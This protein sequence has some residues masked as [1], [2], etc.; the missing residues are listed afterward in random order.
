MK[1]KE[2]IL[3]EIA[4]A[5]SGDKGNHANIGIIARHKEGFIFLKGYLTIER[6]EQFFSP[7]GIHKIVRYELPNL[8]AFNFVL[9][10][11]LGGGGSLSL[12]IDSQGKALGQVFLEM[13]IDIPP[14]LLHKENA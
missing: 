6:V 10:D 14:H 8:N 9:F 7:L 4:Y 11:V 5:R 1:T 12:R 13:P 3:G 2:G